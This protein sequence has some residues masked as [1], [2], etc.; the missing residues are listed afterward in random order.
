MLEVRISQDGVDGG[1]PGPDRWEA[2]DGVRVLGQ[3]SGHSW[4]PDPKSPRNNSCMNVRKRRGSSSLEM[5]WKLVFMPVKR[6][7][8]ECQKRPIRVKKETH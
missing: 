5:Y 3:D 1:A 7:L 6:D 2:A 8:L 4:A